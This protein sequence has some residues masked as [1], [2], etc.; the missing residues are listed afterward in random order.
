MLN[1]KEMASA[2]VAAF[3]TMLANECLVSSSTR[4]QALNTLLFLYRDVLYR[5]SSWLEEIGRST[6]RKRIP[7]VLTV[8]EVEELLGHSDVS[9]TMIYT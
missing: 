7:L 4:R 5:D 3:L 1:P 6:E 2:E 8:A 9:T